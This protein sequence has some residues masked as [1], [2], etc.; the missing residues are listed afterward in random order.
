MGDPEYC[1]RN[2][3]DFIEHPVVMDVEREQESELREG[4]EGKDY[5][6]R[7][8]QLHEGDLAPGRIRGYG[9]GV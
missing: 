6:G 5:R 4:Q 9:R 8:S 1:K 3:L 7:D 2:T